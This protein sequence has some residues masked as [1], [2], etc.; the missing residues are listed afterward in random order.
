M[1]KVGQQHGGPSDSHQ[2]EEN[3]VTET[4]QKREGGRNWRQ[5]AHATFHEAKQKKKKW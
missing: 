4:F 2:S 5:K 1:T 3:N